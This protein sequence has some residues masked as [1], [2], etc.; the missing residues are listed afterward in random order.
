MLALGTRPGT[1][2]MGGTMSDEPLP[3]ATLE[4]RFHVW[5]RHDGQWVLVHVI[6]D[7]WSGR[8][9]ARVEYFVD[10]IPT[11]VDCIDGILTSGQGQQRA[12]SDEEPSNPST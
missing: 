10:N 7:Y 11:A 4:N 5:Q 12:E 1:A 6:A 8:I 3:F 2:L 9:M